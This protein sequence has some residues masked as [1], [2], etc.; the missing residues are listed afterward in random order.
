LGAAGGGVAQAASLP[1]SRNRENGVAGFAVARQDSRAN[2]A[3]LPA[4]EGN[5][6]LSVLRKNVAQSVV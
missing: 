4:D 2:A 3:I 6:L 1:G 5:V